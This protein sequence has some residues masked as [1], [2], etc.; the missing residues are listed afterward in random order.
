[1]T[2]IWTQA[3]P[4]SLSG[5]LIANTAVGLYSIR[6]RGNRY[7]VRRDG[8]VIDIFIGNPRDAR[9]AAERDMNRRLE[10]H[11]KAISQTE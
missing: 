7:I 4:P 2:P 5:D 11:A 3:D 8:L 6:R 9:Q 1:M 10:A